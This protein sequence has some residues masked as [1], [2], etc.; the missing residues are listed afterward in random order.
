MAAR[1]VILIVAPIAIAWTI[2]ARVWREVKR[3]PLYVHCDILEELEQIRR[4]WRAKS[5]HPEHW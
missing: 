4:A 3:I 5:I 2:V 1:I